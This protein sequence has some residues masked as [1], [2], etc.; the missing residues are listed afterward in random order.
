MPAISISRTQMKK[1]LQSKYLKLFVCIG[2]SSYFIILF[3]T[4]E[5]IESLNDLMKISGLLESYTFNDR[6]GF[7]QMGHQYY[8]KLDRYSN[9]FQIKADYLNYFNSTD[10]K[11]TVQTGDSVVLSI[12]KK[13]ADKLNSLNIV[14]ATSIKVKNKTYLS[15]ID[16]IAAEASD[17][18]LFGAGLFLI[19]GIVLYKIKV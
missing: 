18:L 2:F 14:T 12:P 8:I 13:Q 6:T 5:K 1:Y 7:K 3:F 10:F 11:T 4:R 19:L 9:L 17:G 16:V 15:E